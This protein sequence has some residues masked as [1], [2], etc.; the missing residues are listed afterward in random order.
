MPFDKKTIIS[1][2]DALIL[3]KLPKSMVVIGGGV[4]GLELGSVYARLGTEVTVVEFM[5]RILPPM[6]KELGKTLQRSLKK[7][8]I[9]FHLSTKVT[10][11]K[12]NGETVTVSAEDKKGNELQFEADHAL[13]SVGRRPFTDGL[14][15]ENAGVEVGERGF[16]PV[17]H[18]GQ[19]NQ[20]HIFA[21]GDVIGGSMLAHKAEEE[22]VYAVEFMNG[23]KPFM[24]HDLIPGVVY[25]WPEVASVGKSEEQLK[26]AGVKFKNGK[27]PFRAS[28]RARASE[29]SEG[30]VKVLADEETDRILGVHMIGPRCAD[31]I[32]EAVLAMEYKASAEDVARVCHAHPTYTESFKEAALMATEN[33]PI[34]I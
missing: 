8:G 34:H 27:F 12:V 15:L 19:T 3:E 14:G 16:I 25:T 7:L 18:H 17:N 21:I 9:K 11:A 1:S 33:R 6:D 31:L 10:G 28:G 29:E 24:D 2:T 32:A 13:V 26:E 23:E 20:S 5:D 4:I 30:F 22:G